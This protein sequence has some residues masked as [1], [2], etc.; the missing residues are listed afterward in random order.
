MVE[1]ECA[2]CLRDY[3]SHSALGLTLL[4]LGQSMVLVLNDHSITLLLIEVS[5]HHVCVNHGVFA[6]FS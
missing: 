4:R 1:R 2:Q 6:C 5:G 3:I